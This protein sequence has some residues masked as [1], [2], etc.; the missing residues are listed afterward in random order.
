MLDTNTVSYIARNRSPE[1]R[2]RFKEAE[3]D[4]P[5]Y[6]SAITEAEIRYGL[7]KRPQARAVSETMQEI[8]QQLTILPWTSEEACAYGLLR[9]RNESLGIAVGGLDMLIAAHAIAVG[10]VLVTNDGA[11]SKLAGGPVTENWA[12]DIRPN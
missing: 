4:S 1:A 11:L 8:L 3:R 12:D 7:A 9:A 2:R 5:V 10:A 6:V